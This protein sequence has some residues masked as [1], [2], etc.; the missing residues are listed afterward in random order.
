MLLVQSFCMYVNY[1]DLFLGFTAMFK[2]RHE[3]NQCLSPNFLDTAACVGH[4][5]L[6]ISSIF[7]LLVFISC[8]SF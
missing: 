6:L 2:A 1:L 5:A 3:C 8:T 7:D 4:G